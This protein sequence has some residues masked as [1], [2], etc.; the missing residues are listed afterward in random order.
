MN[1][2]R[3]QLQERGL[4]RYTWEVAIP[5]V[6]TYWMKQAGKTKYDYY[7]YP[8]E[9]EAN[10]LGGASFAPSNTLPAFPGEIENYTVFDLWRD[11]FS[12]K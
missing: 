10:T 3:L 2:I 5:S 12:F 1:T 4:F 6:T 9:A 8:W 7:T 11:F